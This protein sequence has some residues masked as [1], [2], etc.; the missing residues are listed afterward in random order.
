MFRQCFLYFVQFETEFFCFD[1]ELLQLFLKEFVLF[2]AGG[3]GPFGDDC[4]DAGEDFEKAF[5]NQ[6]LLDFVGGVGVDFEGG[7]HG[8]HRGEGVTGAELA[9]EDGLFGGVDHLLIERQSGLELYPE[10]NHRCMITH[11]TPAGKEFIYRG[12][13]CCRARF[14]GGS[15]VAGVGVGYNGVICHA[16]WW[17]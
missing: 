13:A 17:C 8:A 3:D 15:A 4:A 14:G 10:R 11:S 2:G 1:H 9:G 12:D 5:G 16:F 6:M 7:A